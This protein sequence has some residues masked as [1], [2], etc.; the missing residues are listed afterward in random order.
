MRTIIAGSRIID[1]YYSLEAAIAKCG[2]TPTVVISGM[3]RGVDYLGIRYATTYSIPIEKHPALWDVY[4]KSAGYQRNAEMADVAEALIVLWDGRSNGTRNMI[5][6]A[7][8][9]LLKIHI[10]VFNIY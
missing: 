1:D 8:Q 7:G 10:E 4:G 3:A 6:L 5:E 2:W 9:R